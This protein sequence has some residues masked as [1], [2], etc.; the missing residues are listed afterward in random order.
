ML[1]GVIT[2][3]ALAMSV[4]ISF[5]R[6]PKAGLFLGLTFAGALAA[7]SLWL[8]ADGR[9]LQVLIPGD[10]SDGSEGKLFYLTLSSRFFHD[11]AFLTGPLSAAKAA[12]FSCATFFL[13]RLHVGSEP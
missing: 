1:A 6:S 2:F 5:W 11:F 4:G 10:A 12:L 9:H 13:F 7:T 8:I 3:L